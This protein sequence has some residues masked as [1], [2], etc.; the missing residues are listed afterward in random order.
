MR[1]KDKEILETTSEISEGSTY[2]LAV[3]LHLSEN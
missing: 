3:S 2:L 1:N